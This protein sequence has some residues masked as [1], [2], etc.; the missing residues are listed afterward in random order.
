MK[1]SEYRKLSDAKSIA[2]LSAETGVSTVSLH[3]YANGKRKC[4]RYDLAQR[5]SLATGGLV[6]IA[7]LCERRKKARQ[8]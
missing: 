2:K 5:I 3:Y 6:S 8:R 1:L 7:E 4:T